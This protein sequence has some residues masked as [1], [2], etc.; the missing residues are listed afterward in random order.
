QSSTRIFFSRDALL[1]KALG[2]SP[3]DEHCLGPGNTYFIDFSSQ[4]I[5]GQL[6]LLFTDTELQAVIDWLADSAQFCTCRKLGLSPTL[7]RGVPTLQAAH[8]LCE[9]GKVL[10]AE[11][12]QLL[13]LVGRRMV[14]FGVGLITR[15]DTATGQVTQMESPRLAKG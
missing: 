6:G 11:Q 13:K 3:E 4:Q 15:W 7:N 9:N 10:T 5:E 14:T 2:T 8:K 12:A 1:A